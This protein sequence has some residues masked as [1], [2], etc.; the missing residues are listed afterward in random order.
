MCFRSVRPY[1]MGTHLLDE[2]LYYESD[3]EI[4]EHLEQGHRSIEGLRE[5]A[6]IPLPPRCLN[7]IM[8]FIMLEQGIFFG[9]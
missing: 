5:A 3:L 8:L 2:L 4:E 1:E 9:I 7:A 6:D